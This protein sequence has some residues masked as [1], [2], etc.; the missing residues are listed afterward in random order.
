[1]NLITILEVNTKRE[2][3]KNWFSFLVVQ[4]ALVE[5][6]FDWINLSIDTKERTLKGTGTLHFGE[7]SYSIRLAFSPFYPF[8]YDRI[9]I[10]DKSIVYDND[11]HL[12]ANDLSLCLYHPIIDQPLL[13][14]TPLFKIIPW[15]SEW[16]VFYEQWKKYGVWLGKEIKHC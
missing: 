1:M 15:I 11:I 5:K 4:K 3:Q 9:F 13:T 16:I 14:K 8:R 7:K 10:D 6:Y 2:N 12:Y